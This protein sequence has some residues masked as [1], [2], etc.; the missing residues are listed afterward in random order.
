MS[1]IGLGRP[2]LS[3]ATDLLVI[4][5]GLSLLFTFAIVVSGGTASPLMSLAGPAFP[6]VLFLVNMTHFSAS[7]VRLYAKPNAYRDFPFLTLGLPLLTLAL[8]SLAIRF[9][10][11]VG[12]HVMNL[13]LTWSPY[14]YA[15]QA[16]GLALLYCYRSGFSVGDRERLLF[17]V[18]CL[19]PFLYAFV[20]GPT[21]GL[22]WFVP[23]LA[24]LDEPWA[25]LRV[26]ALWLL[27]GA[28]LLL[29]LALFLLS[30]RRDRA[31]PLISLLVMVSNAAWWTVFF[32]YDAFG[33]AT[34]FHGL[35]YLAIVSVVHVKD[36]VQAQ[37]G[38][39]PR[40]ALVFYGAC[41]ALAYL[42]FKAWPFAYVAAGFG[43]AESMLLVIAVVNIHHFVVDMFIWRLRRDPGYRE[44]T[45]PAAA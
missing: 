41:V 34:V 33:W 44:V 9:A 24:L 12:V 37:G 45:A 28:A 6:F 38:S 27:G 25:T 15:A 14:H 31:L 22:E 17:R 11:L 21:A 19:A 29:P 36:R 32:Y 10:D 8:L 35:Q 5:G 7:T 23:K 43:L 18:A 39:A 20:K 16:Y 4:G 42:L 3:P 2:F 40:H 26:G 1:I 30:L 13:Y